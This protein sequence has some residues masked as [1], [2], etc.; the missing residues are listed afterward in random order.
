MLNGHSLGKEGQKTLNLHSHVSTFTGTFKWK[1]STN[2]G[3]TNTNANDNFIKSFSFH[4]CLSTVFTRF[5][6]WWTTFPYGNIKITQSTTRFHSNRFIFTI[7]LCKYYHQFVSLHRLAAK[8]TNVSLSLVKSI[9]H[10]AIVLFDFAFAI[11]SALIRWF[12]P[13]YKLW[14]IS[15]EIVVII[16]AAKRERRLIEPTANN[17]I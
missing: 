10:L 14:T 15:F 7:I 6:D 17:G 11:F 4:L 1:W 9:V 12:F 5:D 3:K 13:I 8:Q 16:F 2:R